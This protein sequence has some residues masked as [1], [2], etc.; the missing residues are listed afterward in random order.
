MASGSGY[1]LEWQSNDKA[2]LIH[3]CRGDHLVGEDVAFALDGC[4]AELQDRLRQIDISALRTCPP[5]SGALCVEFD[6]DL[7]EGDDIATNVGELNC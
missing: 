3:V 5:P 7:F 6:F 1:I 4:R 2:G